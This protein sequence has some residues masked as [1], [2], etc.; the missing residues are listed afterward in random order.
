M[1]IV[2]LITPVILCLIFTACSSSDSDESAK[3]KQKVIVKVT[4]LTAPVD[5][6]ESINGSTHT[7][8]KD[9]NHELTVDEGLYRLEITSSGEQGCS[10][11]S[12]LDL[13]CNEA[14]TEEYA[15]VCAKKPFVNVCVTTPCK[16]DVYKTFSNSCVAH[17]QNALVA[18]TSEC[19]NLE[20]VAT[21][22]SKPVRVV[23]LAVTDYLSDPFK[24]VEAE[25][26]GDMLTVKTEV[27]G[28]C[29]THDVSVYVDSIITNPDV[30]PVEISV[31]I[32]HL[33]YDNCEEVVQV[34]NQF[35]LLAVK[36]NYRRLFPEFNGSV[37]LKLNEFGIYEFEL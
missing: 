36:E 5:L 21:L 23:P 37:R 4:G 28:G 20:N 15:P 17:S 19:E 14:C 6:I 8:T 1:K 2:Q 35:D 26:N 7:I 32:A 27:N 31:G 30:E 33:D 12:Q 34:S 29:G 16:T 25:V 13:V 24:L 3:G 10:L 9:G 22:H 11:S 18:L